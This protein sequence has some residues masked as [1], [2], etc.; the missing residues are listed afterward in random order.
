MPFS[1]GMK[2][3]IPVYVSCRKFGLL[4]GNGFALA[5]TGVSRRLIRAQD[6]NIRGTRS[7]SRRF[8]APLHSFTGLTT[9]ERLNAASVFLDATAVHDRALMLRVL[10]HDSICFAAN[11]ARASVQSGCHGVEGG[12][13]LLAC[14]CSQ[15]RLHEQVGVAERF[16]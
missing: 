4:H 13:H 9:G 8:A 14:L 2:R 3:G 16:R 1:G 12:K 10:Q 7:L 6:A 15:C 5:F 11:L